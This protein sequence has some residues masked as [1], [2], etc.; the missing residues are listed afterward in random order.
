MI[1][2]TKAKKVSSFE[3]EWTKGAPFETTPMCKSIN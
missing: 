2:L 3:K 1:I